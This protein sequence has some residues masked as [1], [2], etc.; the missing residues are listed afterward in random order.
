M[1]IA[2]LLLLFLII[3]IKVLKIYKLSSQIK[4]SVHIVIITGITWL[5]RIEETQHDY[6]II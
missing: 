3:I 6:L 1:Q 4:T 2:K 5:N